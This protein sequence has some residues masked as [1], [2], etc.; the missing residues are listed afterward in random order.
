MFIARTARNNVFRSV[1]AQRAVTRG[2]Y[3]ALL[4]R[5]GSSGHWF[6]KHFVPSGLKASV[7]TSRRS[8]LLFGT[9]EAGHKNGIDSQT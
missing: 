4:E 6:Y 5:R 2:E 7:P 8:Y 3:L 1:G 9:L